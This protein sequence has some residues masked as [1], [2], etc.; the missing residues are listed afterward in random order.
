MIDP[1]MTPHTCSLARIF[2]ASS[3]PFFGYRENT[4]K[5]SKNGAWRM[6]RN[7][8]SRAKQSSKMKTSDFEQDSFA[9]F[10]TLLV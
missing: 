8:K 10:I 3:A 1:A 9:V 5:I 6:P 7:P 2:W 4:G